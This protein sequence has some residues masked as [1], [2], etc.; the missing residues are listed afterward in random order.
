MVWRFNHHF[1]RTDSIHLVKESFTFTVQI[2]LDAQRWKFVRHHADAPTGGVWTAAVPSI[3]KN[4]RR[5]ARFIPRTEGTIFLFSGDDALSKE[6]VRALS[7]FRRN[8]HPSAR[9]RV[10]PQL[11][12]S[13]P[14]PQISSG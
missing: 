2:A 3:D 4:L 11:R 5:S 7:S 13:N 14:P 8:D 9:D 10:F 12:H 1:M 6:V